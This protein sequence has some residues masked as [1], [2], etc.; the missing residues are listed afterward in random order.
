MLLLPHGSDLKQFH[1][2][3]LLWE[4]LEC[5]DSKAKVYFSN[6]LR[7]SL[8]SSKAFEGEGAFSGMLRPGG[9]GW[10]L[11]LQVL[12]KASQ[13]RM[14]RFMKTLVR[15]LRAEHMEGRGEVAGTI[16]MV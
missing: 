13:L 14:F 10:T 4:G 7:I 5:A 16:N 11:G 3:I 12:Q 8:A 2:K 9:Q 6:K 1:L 15:M